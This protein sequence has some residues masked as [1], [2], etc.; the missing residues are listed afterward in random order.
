M[1]ETEHSNGSKKAAALSAYYPSTEGHVLSFGALRV[2]LE[3]IESNIQRDIILR[4]FS[5]T[6]DALTSIDSCESNRCDGGRSGRLLT[7][8]QYR[9][10]PDKVI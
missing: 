1:R 8:L 6:Y 10:W 2:K 9:G 7:H 5:V 4:K 3:S